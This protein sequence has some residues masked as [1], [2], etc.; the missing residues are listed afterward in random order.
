MRLILLAF[1]LICLFGCNELKYNYMNGKVFGTY[2]SVVYRSDKSLDSAIIM[3]MRKVDNSLSIF[4]PNSTISKINNSLESETDS[5]M[6]IILPVALN[7]YTA[8]NGAFDMTVGKLVNAWGFGYRNEE[9]PS[10]AKIDSLLR[11]TGMDKLHIE[12]GKVVKNNEAV[13]LDGGA[14]AKGLGVD[15]VAEYLE[16][17]GVE[18]YMV[19]IG[20]EVR[21]KGESEKRRKWRIGIDK[22]QD[23]LA[24]REISVLLQLSEGALA[25]SGNYR[26]FYTKDGKKY[27]HTIDP[28][29]GQPVQTDIISSTVYAKSCMIA[30]AYATAFMVMGLDK[31][32]KLVEADTALEACFMYEQNDTVKIR[33]TEGFKKLVLKDVY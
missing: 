4:N 20:G 27:A 24:T 13:E 29:T 10:Q 21:V 26:N 11:F 5:L 12:T 28:R 32:Y 2:Y 30:D 23:N 8:T 7:V 14:I 17:M 19:D 31:S 6:D 3:Q 16:S 18:N 1:S 15:L 25:T 9:I 22:P 33:M